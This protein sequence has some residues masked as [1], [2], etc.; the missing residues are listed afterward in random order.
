MFKERRLQPTNSNITTGITIWNGYDW[1]VCE[2]KKIAGSGG[3]T[4]V[5]CYGG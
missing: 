3:G 4:T 1:N 2:D 5:T